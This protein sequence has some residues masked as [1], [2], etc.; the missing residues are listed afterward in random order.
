MKNSVRFILISIILGFAMSSCNLAGYDLQIGYDYKATTANPQT[1]KTVLEFIKSRPDIFS[2]ML[3]AIEYTGLDTLYTQQG[4]TYLLLT[5]YSL[6]NLDHKGSYFFMNKLDFYKRVSGS[7]WND[8]SVETVREMLKYH[9]VKGTYNFDQLT[10]T[11]VWADTHAKGDTCKMSFVLLNNEK[12]SLNI[13]NNINNAS[14]N[15]IVPKTPGL[16]CTNSGAVHVMDKYVSPPS[17]L[18]LGIR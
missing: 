11:R 6:N 10:S 18:Q 3:E 13:Q 14:Y 12:A 7:S 2:S 8:Y 5:D 4:N 1:N 15:S 17:K 16:K 9:V